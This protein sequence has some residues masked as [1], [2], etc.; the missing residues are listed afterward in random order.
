MATYVTNP[1]DSP[2]H[3]GQTVE[4]VTV[5][6]DDFLRALFASFDGETRPV[7]VSFLGDP[8]ATT[9]RHWAGRPW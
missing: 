7:L 2:V 4:T 1:A 3:P 6:N 8:R 5:S 9:G